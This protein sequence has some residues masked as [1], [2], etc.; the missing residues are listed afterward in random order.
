MN[1]HVKWVL[2]VYLV[3]GVIVFLFVGS[4]VGWLEGFFAGIM[5][6]IALLMSIVGI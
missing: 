4:V 1:N 6:P 5:W 2:G 3:V